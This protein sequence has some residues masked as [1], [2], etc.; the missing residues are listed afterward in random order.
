MAS[1]PVNEEAASTKTANSVWTKVEKIYSEKSDLKGYGPIVLPG[2]VVK[3]A[4]V[5]KQFSLVFKHYQ[6]SVRSTPRPF[7]IIPAYLDLNQDKALREQLTLLVKWGFVAPAGPIVTGK[8]T[9]TPEEF[10][11]AL[12]YFYVQLKVVTY[13]PDPTWTATLAPI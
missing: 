11:D 7:R 9:L 10:G 1:A 8:E 4:D 5:V 12:A 13:Q 2:T 3:R 6:L